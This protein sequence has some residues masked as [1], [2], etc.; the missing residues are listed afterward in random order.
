MFVKILSSFVID[1][2]KMWLKDFFV[3]YC[4]E[5]NYDSLPLWFSKVILSHSLFSFPFLEHQNYAHD[6]VCSHSLSEYSGII[7]SSGD[8]LLYEVCIWG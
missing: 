1:G 6:Y 4:M 8:G 3:V 5:F 2:H 7:I